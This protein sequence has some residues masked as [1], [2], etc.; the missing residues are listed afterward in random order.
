MNQRA[1]L[2]GLLLFVTMTMAVAIGLKNKAEERNP[3]N[4]ENVLGDNWETSV[5]PI[6]DDNDPIVEENKV[7]IVA[8]DYKD[9]IK[10]SGE[11]GMPV[12]VFFEADWCGWCTKMKRESLTDAK[13][14]DVMKNYILV[15]VDYDKNKS[16]ARKFGVQSLPSYAITNVNEKSLKS[17]GGYLDGNGFAQWLDNPDMYEQPKEEE[18]PNKDDPRWPKPRPDDSPR[19]DRRPG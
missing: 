10:K 11:K 9:A 5:S 16:V 7:Q 2:V 17:D 3:N 8:S 13:V 4:V 6:A 12:L 14:K 19:N 15:Y 1:I 18:D